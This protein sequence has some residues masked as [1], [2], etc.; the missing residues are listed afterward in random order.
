MG[1][2]T[3]TN[4]PPPMFLPRI[5]PDF[6]NPNSALPVNTSNNSSNASS[7]ALLQSDSNQ[8]NWSFS[9]YLNEF[10]PRTSPDSFENALPVNNPSNA[11]SPASVPGDSNQ[12]N[13]SFA[14]SIVFSSPNSANSQFEDFQPALKLPKSLTSKP[15]SKS[16]VQPQSARVL[17][18]PDDRF[19]QDHEVSLPRFGNLSAREQNGLL[20]CQSINTHDAL[21]TEMKFSRGH[22]NSECSQQV[23]VDEHYLWCSRSAVRISHL[24]SPFLPNVES[25][26]AVIMHRAR[27]AYGPQTQRTDFKFMYCQKGVRPALMDASEVKNFKGWTLSHDLCNLNRSLHTLTVDVAVILASAEQKRLKKR[28]HEHAPQFEDMHSQDVRLNLN[29]QMVYEPSTFRFSRFALCSSASMLNSKCN[30]FLRE[31][32]STVYI[33]LQPTLCSAEFT[34]MMNQYLENTKPFNVSLA[35]GSDGGDMPGHRDYSSTVMLSTTTDKSVFRR[36]CDLACQLY[37]VFAKRLNAKGYLPHFVLVG[38]KGQSTV[39]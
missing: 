38:C 15:V 32:S 18:Q 1:D 25:K 37:I 20:Y 39:F 36:V 16:S 23:F 11:S 22:R 31:P 33:L 34:A 14:S 4:N 13:V 7:P 5:S 21:T 29:F 12:M 27:R 35:M 30:T 24:R 6:L 3:D 19:T 9:S 2:S 10:A 28:T 26:Q 8:L 17:F